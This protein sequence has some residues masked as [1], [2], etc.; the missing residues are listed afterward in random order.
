MHEYKFSRRL[1]L[2][3]S[4]TLERSLVS[5][6]SRLVYSPDASITGVIC[7]SDDLGRWLRNSGIRGLGVQCYGVYF[8]G[9]EMSIKEFKRPLKCG[10]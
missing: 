4:L 9:G 6:G 10:A 7:S 2:G 8:S 5:Y 3:E 1:S